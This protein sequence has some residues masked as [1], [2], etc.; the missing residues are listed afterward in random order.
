LRNITPP[1]PDLTSNIVIED[2]ST[3]SI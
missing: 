3:D 2:N 1:G